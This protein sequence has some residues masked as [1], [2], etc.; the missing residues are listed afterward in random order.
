MNCEECGLAIADLYRAKSG[1]V[2]LRGCDNGH[3]IYQESPELKPKVEEIQ[4]LLWLR[5][6][7]GVSSGQIQFWLLEY[8][9]DW[10]NF[11]IDQLA[12]EFQQI[13]DSPE[14]AQ[15]RAYWHYVLS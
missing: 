2:V 8:K 11:T 5:R 6:C 1:D 13:V 14:Y 10:R 12:D 4:R 7:F 15:S 3:I 9:S